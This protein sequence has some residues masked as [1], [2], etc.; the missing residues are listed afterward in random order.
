[1][2]WTSDARVVCQD[3]TDRCTTHS[4]YL[5][6]GCVVDTINNNNI[7]SRSAM[8]GFFV[9]RVAVIVINY[10]HHVGLRYV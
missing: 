6:I 4:G 3:V 2:G 9:P 7:E 8:V 5:S 1:M 10:L